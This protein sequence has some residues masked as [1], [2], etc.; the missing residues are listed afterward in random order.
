[1]KPFSLLALVALFAAC[2]PVDG[3]DSPASQSQAAT[4]GSGPVC[5]D[6]G[7]CRIPGYPAGTTCPTPGAVTCWRDRS[8]YT[9]SALVNPQACTTSNDCNVAYLRASNGGIRAV[10]VNASALAAVNVWQQKFCGGAPPAPVN[11]ASNPAVTDD[12]K[13]I[14]IVLVGCCNNRCVTSR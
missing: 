2:A 8:S 13:L 14:G 4:I 12:N 7:V 10:G 3:S 11:N 1:M 5:T 6:T 9:Y